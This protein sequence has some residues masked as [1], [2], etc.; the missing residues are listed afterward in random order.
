[1]P[2][3]IEKDRD[4]MTNSVEALRFEMEHGRFE[5]DLEENM[6][7]AQVRLLILY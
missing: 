2:N 1:M 7:K 5:C 6:L 4:T 3:Q